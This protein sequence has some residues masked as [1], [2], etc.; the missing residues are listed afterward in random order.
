[1]AAVQS[2]TL[3]S[4][5]Q[6][7]AALRRAGFPI[8]M[9]PVM[10]AI[11][12]AESGD[13]KHPGFS[14]VDAVSPPNKNGT[15]DR[16]VWQINSVHGFNPDTLLTL[17]GNAAAAKQIYDK[18]GLGAWS[19]YNSGAYKSH[20]TA[21]AAGAASPNAADTTVQNEI[22]VIGG[23]QDAWGWLKTAGEVVTS[24]EFWR[25]VGLI[26]IGAVLILLGAWFY[27]KSQ[28]TSALS[29]MKP[30]VKAAAS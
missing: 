3:V 18:Q 7:A 11:G 27:S 26:I 9:I 29:K 30:T 14:R 20:M 2:S 19:T 24:K 12:L 1:M 25:R 6:M 10:V 16:G 23:I 4:P 28:V 8:P 15:I 13:P 5:A 21:A 17:D 22:P